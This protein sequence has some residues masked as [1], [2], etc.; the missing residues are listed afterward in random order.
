MA[1]GRQAVASRK[2]EYPS[3]TRAQTTAS[4]VCACGSDSMGPSAPGPRPTD[5]AREPRGT[6]LLV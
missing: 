4:I 1:V 2:S 6:V 3:R 5:I